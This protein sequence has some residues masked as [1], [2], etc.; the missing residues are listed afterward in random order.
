MQG[1][2]G[3]ENAMGAVAQA[4]SS[5]IPVLLLPAGLPSDRFQVSPMFSSVKN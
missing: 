3:A 1:G 2:P 5:N 4:W